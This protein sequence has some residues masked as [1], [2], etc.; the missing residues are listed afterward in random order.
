MSCMGS[1]DGIDEL[2]G[3]SG[4]IDELNGISG[5]IVIVAGGSGLMIP[6]PSLAGNQNQPLPHPGRG[7]NQRRHR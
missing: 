6:G 1:A 3:I 4:G 7:W 5:G 2:N